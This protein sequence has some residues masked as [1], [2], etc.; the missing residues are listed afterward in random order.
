MIKLEVSTHSGD[1]DIVEV[2]EYDAN[3]ITE[4]RNDHSIEAIAI[5]DRS[6]SRI[7]IKNIKP[8]KDGDSVE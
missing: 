7:D 3:E 2:E 4:K 5:G 6:Y 1:I 8:I